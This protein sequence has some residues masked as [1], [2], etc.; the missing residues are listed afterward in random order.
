MQL[1]APLRALG[2]LIDV[3]AGHRGTGRVWV[4]ATDRVVEE[5]DFICAGHVVKEQFLDFRVVCLLD[6]FIVGEVLL[7]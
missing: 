4:R 7:F 5:G 2:R 3:D 1:D 6:V